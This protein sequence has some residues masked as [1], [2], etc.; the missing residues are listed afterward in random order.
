MDIFKKAAAYLEFVDGGLG[1][2]CSGGLMNDTDASTTIPYLLT[3]HHCISTQASASSLEAF[4][5]YITP[6]CLGSNQPGLGTLP[7]VN[8]ATLLA[9]GG[10]TDFTLMRLPSLPAG[11]GLLGSTNQTVTNGTLLYR[12]SF[13]LGASM[14]YSV[15]SLSTGVATCIDASRPNFLY[16]VRSLGAIFEGSSGSPVMRADGMVVGQLT[17]SCGPTAQADEGCDSSNAIVDGAMAGSW[18]SIVQWLNP[19]PTGPSTC[20]ASASSLCLGANGRFKVE[21]TFDTGAQQGQAQ[22]VKLTDDSGY[23]WFFGA[24]NVEAVVKVLDACSYNS[25]FWVYA[26]GLTNV[27]VVLTVTDTKTGAVKTYTNPRNT[28]FQPIQDVGAFA[29]CP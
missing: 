5:D 21:A 19:A 24:S 1:Y 29:T 14:G 9:T 8:G 26:G 17:G 3:A 11:R 16:S 27:Q 25:R 2:S 6:T 20:V 18:N 13:P 4:F 10:T 23:L 22:V 12:L 28:A 7:R 15:T